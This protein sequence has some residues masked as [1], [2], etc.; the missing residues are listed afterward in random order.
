MDK[1]SEIRNLKSEVRKNGI[2]FIVSAPSGAGKTTLCKKLVDLFPDMSH[3]ISYTTRPPRPG[4]IDGLD[5]Y[6]VNQDTFQRMVNGGEFLEWAEVHGYRYGTSRK[7]TRSL[8][9]Q[10]LDVI[11]DIDVQGAK[12]IKSGQW[13]VT[14]GQPTNHSTIFIFVLPPSLKACEERLRARGKDSPEEI[15][16]RLKTAEAEI[17]EVSW[18]DY[19]IINDEFDVALERL[20]S[21]VIAERSKRDMMMEEVERLYG[22]QGN[23]ESVKG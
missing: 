17:R 4:E 1:R 6:F 10:G 9:T 5:Y 21:I 16:R 7:D 18:Y 2:L 15:L 22:I 14:G 13:S 3:S 12:Q 11:L 19:I 23:G 20:K 8:L